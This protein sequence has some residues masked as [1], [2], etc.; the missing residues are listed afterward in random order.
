MDPIE[1]QVIF[2]TV[3]DTAN[4]VWTAQ[5]HIFEDQ[6]AYEGSFVYGYRNKVEAAFLDYFNM[7][8]DTPT[9]R[10]TMHKLPENWTASLAP[11]PFGPTYRDAYNNPAGVIRVMTPR[12]SM[13]IDNLRMEGSE[14]YSPEALGHDLAS[15]ALSPI[16]GRQ[17][18]P[19][20]NGDYWWSGPNLC[21]RAEDY[22]ISVFAYTHILDFEVL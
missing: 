6:L 20:I 22:M 14:F 5:H 8:R 3:Q 15:K 10:F 1:A 7:H 19:D 4:A 21:F 17:V 16:G 18:R 9:S 13:D 2:D 12:S 11:T